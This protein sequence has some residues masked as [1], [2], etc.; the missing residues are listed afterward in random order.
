MR[1]AAATALCVILTIQPVIRKRAERVVRIPLRVPLACDAVPRFD[2]VLE[3]AAE[4]CVPGG[5]QRNLAASRASFAADIAPAERLLLADAQTSGGLL[6]C[7]PAA[8]RDL[9]LAELAR[10]DTPAAAV[11]GRVVPGAPGTIDVRRHL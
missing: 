5:T 2:G 11:I 3:L 4:G 6:L 7:V 1:S 10:H 9:L 8:A